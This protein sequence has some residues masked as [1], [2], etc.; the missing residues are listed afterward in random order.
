MM[1]LHNSDGAEMGERG[2]FSFCSILKMAY[3]PRCKLQSS[4]AERSALVSPRLHLAYSLRLRSV[5]R[6]EGRDLCRGASAFPSAPTA[7]GHCPAALLEMWRQ[8]IGRRDAS[9]LVNSSAAWSRK[10]AG[11][12]ARTDPISF[13][14]IA[15]LLYR[16]TN[17]KPESYPGESQN[18]RSFLFSYPGRGE[19]AEPLRMARSEAEG[20]RLVDSA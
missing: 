5:D 15:S 2:L 3:G 1:K 16:A 4:E 12:L 14:V 9:H 18:L 17:S 13:T 20:H 10:R 7:P 11:E 6:G 19:G 8:A